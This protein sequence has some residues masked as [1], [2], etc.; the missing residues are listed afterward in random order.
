MIVVMVIGLAVDFVRSLLF[1]VVGKWL[2]GSKV[3][4]FLQKVD[5]RLKG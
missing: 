3:D 1:R 4:L 2:S 5:E